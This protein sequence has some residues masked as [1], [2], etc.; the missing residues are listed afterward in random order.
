MSQ[1][2]VITDPALGNIRKVRE[3]A[4]APETISMPFQQE[5]EVL[6]AHSAF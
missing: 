6:E 2:G 3:I 5:E 4:I 1:I